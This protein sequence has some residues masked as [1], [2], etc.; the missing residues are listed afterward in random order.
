MT[1]VKRVGLP[2]LERKQVPVL[3][4]Q[5]LTKEQVAT[6]FYT[7]VDVV[8]RYWPTPTRKAEKVEEDL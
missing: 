7:T 3:A 4:A 5:G 6:K 8:E 1:S 2:I